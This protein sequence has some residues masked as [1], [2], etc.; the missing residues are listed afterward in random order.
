MSHYLKGKDINDQISERRELLSKLRNKR[1]LENLQM[2]RETTETNI[3][4]VPLQQSLPLL[5][6]ED[7]NQL[8]RALDMINQRL[9]KTNERETYLCFNVLSYFFNML[10]SDNFQ[11][12]HKTLCV[13]NNIA[14]CEESFEHLIKYDHTQIVQCFFI[15]QFDDIRVMAARYLSCVMGCNKLFYDHLKTLGLLK[16][17][18]MALNQYHQDIRYLSILCYFIG[19]II[20]MTDEKNDDVDFQSDKENVE[21]I[22]KGDVISVS[23][24]QQNQQNVITPFQEML[25]Y[26]N[27]LYKYIDQIPSVYQMIAT[28]SLVQKN[29]KII[30]KQIPTLY[31]KIVNG[32]ESSNRLI[33]S[34][35]LKTLQNISAMKLKYVTKLFV[36][37]DFYHKLSLAIGACEKYDFADICTLCFNLIAC[38]NSITSELLRVNA[39]QRLFDKL[40]LFEFTGNLDDYTYDV[41]WEF[42]NVFLQ[43]LATIK[44]SEFSYVVFSS[45]AFKAFSLIADSIPHQDDEYIKM[46]LKTLTNVYKHL[47][48]IDEECVFRFMDLLEES[49]IHDALKCI[50]FV[51]DKFSAE[52]KQFYDMENSFHFIEQN[53]EKIPFL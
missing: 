16:A 26:F 15:H 34:W 51:N 11:I 52:L 5:R 23:F 9:I 40:K 20:Y 45:Y 7:P 22:Q 48:T 2:H 14:V 17:I 6:S 41:K 44:P 53:D 3:P 10:Q 21:M 38:D 12:I 43:I 39:I 35:C 29:M 32:L 37:T 47:S 27:F 30:I 33:R 46:F 25:P 13:L 8:C 36:Q 18:E 1:R 28:I 4:D 31:Q 42:I 49:K 50:D 24:T 19:N